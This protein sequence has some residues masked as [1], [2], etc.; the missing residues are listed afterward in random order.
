VDPGAKIEANR[1]ELRW[2]DSG[3]DQQCPVEWLDLA[4]QLLGGGGAPSD[5]GQL[6]WLLE[7]YRGHVQACPPSIRLPF[8]LEYREMP[9][10][11][12]ALDWLDCP[13]QLFSLELTFSSSEHFVPIEPIRIPF[14]A[15]EGSTAAGNRVGGFP[16]MNK[17]LLKLQPISPVPTSFGV[18]IAFNDC[19]G[20]M[21]FGQLETF[22]VAFQD[23]FLPVRLPLAFWSHLYES[24]W[25]GSLEGACWSVKVLDLDREVV[26]ELIRSQLGPFVVPSEVHLPEE[27]FDFEQ[28]EYFE[29]WNALPVADGDALGTGYEE[30]EEEVVLSVETVF[31]VVFIPPCYHLLMRFAIS[32]HTTVV[33]VLTDRFQLLSYMDSFFLS[34]SRDAAA[35]GEAIALAKCCPSAAG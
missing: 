26:Q 29:R 1:W 33:R 4:P 15:Q 32:S 8:V 27:D 6:A 25:Q 31:T 5:S 16:C 10:T 18:N 3:S 34:W 17:L 24:L 13:R 30:D 20:H 21:Y 2:G 28:E 23:L 19:Q 12:E 11:T 14:I 22:N 9:A 35:L 7:E